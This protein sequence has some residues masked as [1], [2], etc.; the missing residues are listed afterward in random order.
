MELEARVGIE[1]THKGFADPCLTTWL[2][3]RRDRPKVKRLRAGASLKCPGSSLERGE[4]ALNVI[5]NQRLDQ[6]VEVAVHDGRKVVDTQ[7]D[8]VVGDAVL[9]EVVGA[10]FLVAFAGADL[11]AALGGVLGVFGGDALVEEPRSE[12]LEGFGLVLLLGAFVGATNDRAGG[13]VHELHRGIRGVNALSARAGGAADGEFEIGV[14]EFDV[15][16]LGF[17]QDGDGGGAGMDASLGFGGRDAL[18]AMDAALVFE[19]FEDVRACDA[20]DDLPQTAKVGAAGVDGLDFP[21]LNLNISAEHAI[22]IG[23]EERGL[24][25]SGPGT[26]LDDGIARVGG[27]GGDD[28][29]LDFLRHALGLGFEAGDFVLGHPD[30]FRV[31]LRGEEGA[32]GVEFGK[33][34][35]VSRPLVLE[36][37]EPGM[38]ARQFLGTLGVGEDLGIAQGALDLGKAL[39]KLR[40]VRA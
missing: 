36:V 20:E 18:D 26:D 39:V 1:P 16:F 33:G 14:V 3:R 40:D 10:N 13:L 4:P 25:P 21:A 22:E 23:G 11:G 24:G 38:F 6:T 32:V 5:G 27:V 12:N 8:A 37:F 19:A 31:G 9:R 15:D 28:A 7:L 35:E 29:R 30:Q 17:R 34:I 2:P